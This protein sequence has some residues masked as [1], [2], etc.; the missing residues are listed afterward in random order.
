M[1][2]QHILLV[3]GCIID[4]TNSLIHKLI[5]SNDGR[6]IFK[7]ETFGFVSGGLMD[8]SVSDF[9]LQE[10]KNHIS[11]ATMPR[12]GFIMRRSSSESLAQQDFEMAIESNNCILDNPGKHDI[13]FDMSNRKSWKHKAQRNIVEPGASGLYSLI[14]ARCRPVGQHFVSFRLDAKFHNPGPNYL[15]AGDA[16]LP[17][18]Y[19]IFFILFAIAFLCWIGVL[20][21]PQDARGGKVHRIH[22]MMALLL[23]L[24]TLSLLFESI[25]YHY[26]SIS[27]ISNAAEAWSIIFYIF[28]FMKGVMLFTVILLIGSGWSLMKG[29]LND[30]EK[31]I[32]FVVLT[33]QVLD[34]VAMVVI[35]ETA[36]GSQEWSTWRDVLHFVDIACC[37][38]ILFPIIWS[39][40]HL[41]QAADVD[42]KAQNNLAKLQLFRQFYVMVVAYIY[43]TRIVVFLLSATIPFYLLWLGPLFTEL[44]TLIFF[45]VTG[46]KFRPAPDNPY[47]PVRMTDTDPEEEFGLKEGGDEDGIE[48]AE[49]VQRLT[50]RHEHAN[51]V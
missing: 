7:I 22:Y 49:K 48:V 8:I 12:V 14:F 34:N 1:K 2:F 21:R 37:C 4:L 23:A 25:R 35:E 44:A 17:T 47:I 13:I 51:D 31:K 28:A 20:S 36:P 5:I 45:A 33:L 6:D 9:Y 19:F 27:G 43:F 10:G 40:R 50:I 39:I 30:K 11:N 26:I 29:Y 15:S 16:P 32:I 46:F 3:F 42:G 41:R 18:V 38:A 24:K